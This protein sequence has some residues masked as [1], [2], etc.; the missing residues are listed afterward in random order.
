MPPGHPGQSCGGL[1]Q[2]DV[3][4]CDFVLVG[5]I[6]TNSFLLI[7]VFVDISFNFIGAFV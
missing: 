5:D 4:S 3:T 7:L 1:L 6:S 2:Q